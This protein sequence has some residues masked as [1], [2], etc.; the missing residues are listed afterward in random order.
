MSNPAPK[1]NRQSLAHRD[2]VIALARAR[3]RWIAGVT[4]QHGMGA[5]V[6]SWTLI[7]HTDVIFGNGGMPTP[8][9]EI[10]Q[11]L[12]HDG[13]DATQVIE[14]HRLRVDAP[15]PVWA[16]II[17][18]PWEGWRAAGAW[19]L[20]IWLIWI[21]GITLLAGRRPRKTEA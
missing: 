6:Q 16:T 14:R 11:R 17:A 12:S 2:S 9:G 13:A 21:W 18:V 15:W 5:T 10:L 3:A 1:A 7:G 8:C 4:D 20:L 19:Q